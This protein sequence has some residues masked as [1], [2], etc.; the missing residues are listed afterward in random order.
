MGGM[1][2]VEVMQVGGVRVVRVVRGAVCRIE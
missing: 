2:A 1:F